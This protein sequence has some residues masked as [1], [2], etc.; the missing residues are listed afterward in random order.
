MFVFF[1]RKCLDYNKCEVDRFARYVNS[2]KV[3]YISYSIARRNPGFD[4]TL[5]PPVECGESALTYDQWVG[6]ENAE[7]VKKDIETIE[8]KFVSKVEEFVKQDTKVESK[9]GGDDKV[10]ELEGKVAE[11]E[12]KIK[13][14]EEENANLK[15]QLEG[16]EAKPEE[17]A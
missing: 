7:P 14:L 8:N 13:A 3:Y 1:D 12:A 17:T 2:Q 6:L 16:N 9:E 5:Y 15:K 4:K 11:L 10:K